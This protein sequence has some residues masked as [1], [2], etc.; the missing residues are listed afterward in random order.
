[1]NPKL[2][3]RS[4]LG[5]PEVCHGCQQPLGQHR[6]VTADTW[7]NPLRFDNKCQC[8]S[9]WLSA[10]ATAFARKGTELVAQT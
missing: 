7:G 3:V 8:F 5:Q 4:L 2:P 1:M 10:N 6:T 9:K